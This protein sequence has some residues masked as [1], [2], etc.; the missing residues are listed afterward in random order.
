MYSSY[1]KDYS[2]INLR[3]GQNTTIQLTAH[4]CERVRD[5]T[6]YLSEMISFIFIFFYLVPLLIQLTFGRALGKTLRPFQPLLW[7]VTYKK[8]KGL[9]V[10]PC[11]VFWKL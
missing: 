2:N 4:L 5:D 11:K 8:V 10:E 7:S 6:Y 9:K 1:S 3:L